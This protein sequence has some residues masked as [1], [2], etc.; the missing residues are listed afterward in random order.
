MIRTSIVLPAPLYQRLS[1]LAKQDGK[2]LSELVRDLL[3]RCIAEQEQQK[4]ARMY[5]VLNEMDGMIKSN[6]TDASSTVDEVLY[7]ERGA[8]QATQHNGNEK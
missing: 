2:K 5:Q 3:D 8:W 4:T 1:L 6:V 7:G